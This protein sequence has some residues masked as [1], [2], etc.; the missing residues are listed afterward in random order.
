MRI[1]QFKVNTHTL[2]TLNDVLKVLQIKPSLSRHLLCIRSLKKD[3]VLAKGWL[4][5]D[6][7]AKDGIDK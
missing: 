6:P 1:D 7:E 4:R 3:N 5:S 2:D